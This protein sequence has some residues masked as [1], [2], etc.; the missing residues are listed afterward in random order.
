M[1]TGSSVRT[2]ISVSPWSWTR[3]ASVSDHTW[4]TGMMDVMGSG[5]GH[6]S[7]CFPTHNISDE[8]GK[9]DNVRSGT[10]DRDYSTAQVSNSL[11]SDVCYG[12]VKERHCVH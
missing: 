7:L 4:S 12:K 10:L 8:Q 2:G 3:I 1:N 5:A 6:V 9:E 11:W